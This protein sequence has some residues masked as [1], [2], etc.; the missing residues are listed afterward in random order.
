MWDP[1]PVSR[2]GSR[3]ELRTSH[4]MSTALLMKIT[5]FLTC[6][7]SAMK[8]EITYNVKRRNRSHKPAAVNA[9]VRCVESSGSR[10]SWLLHRYAHTPG[11]RSRRSSAPVAVS[12]PDTQFSTSS[13]S[14]SGSTNSCWCGATQNLLRISLGT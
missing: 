10:V 14:R 8:D 12:V 6:S 7:T 11:V 3:N 9:S 4:R 13:R 2:D 1:H 5:Y